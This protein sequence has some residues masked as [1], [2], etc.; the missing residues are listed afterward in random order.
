MNIDRILGGSTP[1]WGL[2]IRDSAGQIIDPEDTEKF[3]KAHIEIYN[4][5]TKAILVK[6]AY[7]A[8]QG[9]ETAIVENEQITFVINSTITGEAT[10]NVEFGVVVEA[11]LK[12]AGGL[13]YPN[14]I[15]IIIKRGTLVEFLDSKE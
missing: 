14:N 9:Y 8:E 1:R 7:P 2:T 15:D 5:E 13:G 6:F 3:S 12:V 11:H 4:E 10:K